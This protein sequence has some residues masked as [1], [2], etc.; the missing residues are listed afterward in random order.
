MAKESSKV[1]QMRLN[2]EDAAIMDELTELYDVDRSSLVRHA[3]AYISK[4]KPTFM[5]EIAPLG[6]EMALV[7]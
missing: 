7:A 1:F 2:E 4:T 3:L 5:V 6:K